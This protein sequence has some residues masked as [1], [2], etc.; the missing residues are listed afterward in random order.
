[1]P[2]TPVNDH[3]T[4]SHEMVLAAIRLQD[5]AEAARLLTLYAEQARRVGATSM[6]DELEEYAALRLEGVVILSGGE[7]ELDD[8]HARRLW[9]YENLPGVCTT[10]T[11]A[12]HG[13]WTVDNR[14]YDAY[15]HSADL[16]DDDHDHPVI[17]AM[18]ARVNELPDTGEG[19]PFHLASELAWEIADACL[20]DAA[21]VAAATE[22]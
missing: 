21:R 5:P 8:V 14:E 3:P 2:H 6:A 7:I 4:L 16:S 9:A 10:P 18:W 20:R 1:M 22:D 17:A 11:P 12:P 13:P 19:G 15:R